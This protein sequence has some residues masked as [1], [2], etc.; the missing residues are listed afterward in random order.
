MMEYL[1]GW[2]MGTNFAVRPSWDWVNAF[3]SYMMAVLTTW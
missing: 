2:L 1:K 3:S